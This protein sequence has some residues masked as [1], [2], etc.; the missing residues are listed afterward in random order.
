M[1]HGEND[2]PL[3]PEVE[4]ELDALDAALRG[5]RVDQ[6]WEENAQ[7]AL[8]LKAAPPRPR[9]EF[10]RELDDRAARRFARPKPKTRQRGNFLRG[11]LALAACAVLTIVVVGT[12]NSPDH[13]ADRQAASSA[14]GAPEP[15]SLNLRPRGTARA[16]TPLSGQLPIPAS[17]G[18]RVEH[19]ASLTLGVPRARLEE[20]SRQV[21]DITARV[22]RG[23]V[24]SSSVSAAQGATFQLKIPTAD[25]AAAEA[26]FTQL[27]RVR[28]QTDTTQDITGAFVSADHRL[29]DAQAERSALLRALGRAS[30]KNQADA[31][32]ARLRISEGQ[33]AEAQRDLRV[34][35]R[36]ADLTSLSLTLVP[37]A[38]G[39]AGRG[40]GQFTPAAALRVALR[41]LSVA[42]GVL[43]VALAVGL[44]L[45]AAAGF[46]VTASRLARRRR[47]ER[48]LEGA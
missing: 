16:A 28:A 26:R 27:G 42:L 35:G 24:L 30:T 22:Y 10:A 45:A 38:R 41:I 13:R 3:S 7:L 46:G 44:P 15:E 4:R 48:A 12:A 29:A 18:R 25:L 43:L 47:R 17:A 8:L 33:I 32:R 11:G 14:R 23:Y 39:A 36:R 20:V 34:L 40:K 2:A 31:I 19:A 1:R 21:F 37:E 6:E 9:A 5:E